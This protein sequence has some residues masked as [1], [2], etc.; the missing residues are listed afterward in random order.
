MNKILL[1]ITLLYAPVRVFSQTPTHTFLVRFIDKN[2][3]TYSLLKPEEFLSKK[4]LDRRKNQN[5]PL[6]IEDLPVSPLYVDAL[7]QTGAKVL[8]TSRWFNTATVLTDDSSI[9]EKIN[10]MPIVLSVNKSRK[11]EEEVHAIHQSQLCAD[12]FKERTYGQA[13]NQI[14]MLHGQL[15]HL[16]GYCGQGKLIAV[17]DAGFT[18]VDH[19]SAFNDLRNEK[20]II[21]THDFLEG[22]ADVTNGATHGMMVL[23]SMTGYLPGKLLGTAPGASYILLRTE[24]GPDEYLIEEDAWIAAAEYA[25]SAGADIINSSLGYTD[26]DDTAMNHTYA[27]MNG[28]TTRI[29]RA[30]TI[31]ASKGIVVVSS[32]GNSGSRPWHFISAPADAKDILT[33]GATYSNGLIAPFSSRGPASDGRIKPDV[34]AQGAN[35]AVASTNNGDVLIGSGTSFSSP[36]LAGMVACLWQAFPQK[37]STE[38]REAIVKSGDQYLHPD[39]NRGHGLP[40]FSLAYKILEGL[41]EDSTLQPNIYPN[42]FQMNLIIYFPAQKTGTATVILRDVF[43]RAL[44]NQSFA[45]PDNFPLKKEILIPS[46][47]RNGIYF[48]EIRNV[49][50]SKRIVKLLKV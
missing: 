8:F 5:I 6:N 9:I 49:D 18:G 24:N 35:A 10:S 48:G 22:D 50:G 12:T 27:D 31:A 30:A 32:A 28:V 42:P 20:R 44:M 1:L 26:F 41:P 16:A 7:K 2:F 40:D 46:S 13:W 47:L 19:L 14:K 11:K 37:S 33:V 34:V 45:L 3:N 15:L 17:I 4:A 38:I 29:S 21:A 25:D 23:S 43:G 39:N 36:I